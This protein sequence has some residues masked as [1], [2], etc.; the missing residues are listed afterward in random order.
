MTGTVMTEVGGTFFLLDGA[1]ELTGLRGVIWLALRWQ[2]LRRELMGARGYIAHRLWFASPWT[3]GLTSWW[4][5][6][7][8]AYRFARLPEHRRVW[9]WAAE[10]GHTRGGWL[11][12]YRYVRGGPLWGNGVRALTARFEGRV[13]SASDQ[14]PRRVPRDRPR[15]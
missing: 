4:V 5:D 10:P 3:V 12:H 14:P 11:A 8:S 1:N 7:A 6:E 13:P 15:T 2:A 9:A